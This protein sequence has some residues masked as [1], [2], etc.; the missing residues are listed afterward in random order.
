MPKD[1]RNIKVEALNRRRQ[2]AVKLRLA[3]A[4][5]AETAARAGLSQPTVIGAMKDYRRGGWAAVPVAPRGRGIRKQEI[6][7]IE[8]GATPYAR[9]A[10]LGH[11][12]RLEAE[13][14]HILREVAA[15]AERPVMLY[16]I[17]KDSSVM[18]HLARKAFF[19][20]PPPFPLLHVDTTWKFRD[21]YAFRERMAAQSGMQLLVHCNDE[22][23][24]TGINPFDTETGEYSRL[25]LTET[26]K[27]ALDQYSFD[28]AFGGG[29]RDEE[30]ARA[31][32]RIF[33]HRGA[34]HTW[35]P[36]N[37]RPEL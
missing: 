25:M 13:S 34:G 31:K 23:A 37:Q 7:H 14:I 18:L 27:A 16:S 11:L 10:S 6:K 35:D 32:E 12:Q 17:G 28:A 20:A 30:K 9:L 33:S 3:G 36:R 19:P 8:T 5:V 24:R 1:G 2:R 21:M 29:R 22:A 15:E 26:L 4:S